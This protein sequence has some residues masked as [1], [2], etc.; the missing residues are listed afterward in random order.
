MSG[1]PNSPA[2]RDVIN[3][4]EILETLGNMFLVKVNGE[5]RQVPAT[6]KNELLYKHELYELLNPESESERVVLRQRGNGLIAVGPTENDSVYQLW[7]GDSPYP[8][9]NPPSM[10]EQVLKG[11]RDSIEEP[12]DYTRL[13]QAYEEIRSSQVRR[14]VMEKASS[15][16]SPTEVIPTAD[17]WEVLGLFLL[18]WDARV[19]L[20][21][22][23]AADSAAYRVSGSSVSETEQSRE[24]L[25][26]AMSDSV[27]ERYR[28]L[29][30]KLH[31][32]LS[33]TVDVSG[34]R[35]VET[36]CPSCACETAYEHTPHHGDE[37]TP[38]HP[39]YVCTSCDQPWQEYDLTEREIEFI[40]KAKWLS[41]HRER[42]SDEAF[43][44]VI[45]SYVW[46]N[47]V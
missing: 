26:L 34:N 6:Y 41:Q 18:T 11:V 8:V 20:N 23:N 10:A 12:A 22:E 35:T 44:D 46:Y 43:W 39:V 17:G 25:Q 13:T 16:F 45:E 29:S 21:T 37:E 28:G 14:H 27:L 4:A 36:E 5:T 24:F 38:V 30:L 19:F 2:D 47:E 3:N 42:L 33:P 9:M 40:A 31:Y 15:M 7:V 1:K 32:N